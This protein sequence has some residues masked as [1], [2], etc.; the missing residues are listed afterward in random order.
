VATVAAS[1]TA[2]IGVSLVFRAAVP[3]GHMVQGHF[4]AA[5]LTM[6]AVSMGS[7]WL[8]DW[9]TGGA[10]RAWAPF[11]GTAAG[12][13]AGFIGVFLVF[14]VEG[15]VD[16]WA[17]LT[18]GTSSSIP[19]EHVENLLLFVP[20]VTTGLVA[21]ILTATLQRPLPVRVGILPCPGGGVLA[22]GATF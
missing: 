8:V 7:A 19:Y 2:S 16:L 9:L 11:T 21:G 18:S 1:L 15:A 5:Y 4:V 22:V 12:M 20:A 3:S 6:G 14:M 17:A 13:A 10:T